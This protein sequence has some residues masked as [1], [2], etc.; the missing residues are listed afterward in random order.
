[1]SSTLARKASGDGSEK[2]KPGL[3]RRALRFLTHPPHKQV[4]NSLADIREGLGLGVDDFHEGS[5]PSNDHSLLHE[6]PEISVMPT[7][8]MARL[9]FYAPDMDGQT[10]PGEVVWIWAPADGPQQP[11]RK[12]A[13]VVVGRNRN[14]I[15]GL[16]ISC[17]PEHRTDEDWIDI[18]SGSWDPR[19]RQSWVRLD[20]V[21]EVPELGIR[22]QGTVVPPGRFERI[23]NRLRNDFNWV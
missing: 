13:I 7:E 9:I 5:K 12:R 16:L 1:M 10:D 18:G 15:L 4:D 21:L 3:F 19:G 8:S 6:K 17:N 23:A 20:R 14:A 22:R 2:K 11:P